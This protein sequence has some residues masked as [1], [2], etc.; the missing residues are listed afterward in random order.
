MVNKRKKGVGINNTVISEWIG[1]DGNVKTY[2]IDTAG[3]V[4][5]IESRELKKHINLQWG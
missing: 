3:I 4:P 5:E 2:G 1:N